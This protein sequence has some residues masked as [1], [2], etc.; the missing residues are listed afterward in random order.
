MKLSAVMVLGWVYLYSPLFFSVVGFLFGFQVLGITAC[1]G[2]SRTPH[3][4]TS[5]HTHFLDKI[6]SCYFGILVVL[7]ELPS[8]VL[9]LLLLLYGEHL[10]TRLKFRISVDS[11]RTIDC[12]HGCKLYFIAICMDVLI[13]QMRRCPIVEFFPNLCY[14]I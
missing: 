8:F 3:L 7:A 4:Y 12:V 1:M 14:F 10:V 9:L 5:R 11:F 6:H 2:G 13:K